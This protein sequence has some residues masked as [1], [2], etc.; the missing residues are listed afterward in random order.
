MVAHS[1]E[2][3]NEHFFRPRGAQAILCQEVSPDYPSSPS[4]AIYLLD[5]TSQVS[6]GDGSPDIVE[7]FG[8]V[9]EGLDRIDVF[10]PPDP[11]NNGR[12]PGKT[13][14]FSGPHEARVHWATI[15]QRYDPGNSIRTI[16]DSGGSSLGRP[17]DS[18]SLE[19]NDEENGE[20]EPVKDDS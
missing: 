20:P 10:D 19:I 3:W 18:T 2:W 14:I 6:G 16:S 15:A 12:P 4:F 11:A 5:L 1:T 17:V 9:P 7:R 8:S 13:V